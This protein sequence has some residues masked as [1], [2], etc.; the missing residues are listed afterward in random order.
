M[1][2]LQRKGLEAI[3]DTLLCLEEIVGYLTTAP[4]GNSFTRDLLCL[5]SRMFEVGHELSA[6]YVGRGGE[7]FQENISD[8]GPKEWFPT[9]CVRH[10][11]FSVSRQGT[12]TSII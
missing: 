7:R 3:L 1:Q 6:S 4:Y 12:S 8:E 9:S 5:R 10:S 11:R 2:F